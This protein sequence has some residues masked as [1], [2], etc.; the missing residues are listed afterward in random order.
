MPQFFNLA[1]ILLA[2]CVLSACTAEPEQRNSIRVLLVTGGGWHD[3]VAQ[4]PLL[5]QGL[6]E[7]IP[8]IE[9]T[10]VHEGDKQAD[11]HISVMQED[12]WAADYDLVVHNTS[13]GMLTDGEFVEHMVQH[14]M[15][16][17]AVLIHSAVHSYR[18]AEPTAEPWFRFAGLQSMW[19]EDERVFTVE[20]VAPEDPIMAAFPEKWETPVT[21]E[22]Y[23]VEKIWADITPL[24]RAYGIET[25][26][27]HTVVWKHE[28]ENTRVFATT[29]GHNVDMFEQD[30]YMDTLAK[31]VLWALGR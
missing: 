21:E 6:S 4:E 10:I 29:L 16:T 23:V 1:K 5:T 19:H 27:Y 24:A 2:V 14:H 17:P 18:R 13:F 9:W 11:H 26:T 22:L 31:G 30:V 25:E 7:R 3:Y 12:D 20:N 28:V 15:G 8:E